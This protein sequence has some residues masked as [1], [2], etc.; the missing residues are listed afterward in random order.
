MSSNSSSQNR[1]GTQPKEG[2][3]RR[4]LLL[5]AS[6]LVATGAVAATGFGLPVLRGAFGPGM[7]AMA[8]ENDPPPNIIYIVS[9]DQGWKDVGFH[10][11]DIKTPNIDRLSETGVELTQFYAQPF[12]TQTRAAMLTGRYPLRTGMQT[13]VIPSGG[14]YGVPTDEWLLPQALKD[15]GYETALIG[16]WHIGH[17]KPEY[18]PHQRGFD[19]FYGALVGEIDHFKHEAHGEGDWYRNNDRIEEEG[20]DTTLFGNEA[21]KRI[22]EHDPSKPLYLYL[23]FTAPHTP[24]QAPDE[25]LDK[26]PE[27][28]DTSRRAY[29]AMITAMDDQIGRVLEALDK[30]GMRDNTLVLFHSDNGG[31]RSAKFTG[32]SKVT[33]ELP[34]NNDP[35]RDG[36]A[37]LYEGG[38]RVVALANWP[39]RIKPGQVD[40]MIHVVDMYPTL[41]GLA[42]GTLD[43]SKPLDG[44]DVWATIS[45]G[46]ASPRTEVVYNV[47]PWGAALRQGDWKLIWLALLPGKLELFDLAADPSEAT[48]LAE[49][50]PGKV[51]ELQSRII[52]LATQM[53]QPLFMA[54]AFRTVASAPPSTP[55]GFFAVTD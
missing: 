53:A 40:G 30:R 24:Y 12:C 11:S 2:L 45:E 50:N 19:Y 5:S 33:G 15:A 14:L 46:R 48:N 52:E 55:E 37:T 7:A 34:P 25:Y 44:L 1:T 35:Y 36:K 9:D 4:D 17:A 43:K 47:E 3:Q 20:Y 39:N 54:D 41:V 42:G 32:E 31:T 18:W 51:K 38:T 10:G 29:A 22:E 23:A 21:V 6:A 13:A 16:K 8:A 27:I 26:Y 49:A 28:A